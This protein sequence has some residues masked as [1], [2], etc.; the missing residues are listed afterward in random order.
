MA[1]DPSAV[2]RLARL[3][4]RTQL[5]VEGVLSG[6]HRSP[7]HGQSVEFSEHKEYSPGDEVRH[8]DWK[9]YG[10]FDRYYIKRFE[11]ETNLRAYLVL[12]ASAS[13]GYGEPESK[14]ATATAMAGALASLLAGQQDAVGLAIAHGGDVSVVPA[15]SSPGHLNAIMERL[16]TIQPSGPTDLARLADALAEKTRRRALLLVFSDLFD[17]NPDGLRRLLVLRAQQ[18]DLCLFHLLDRTELAFPFDDP[19]LFLSMED[20]R[21]LEA[22]PRELRKGY[23]EELG[24]FLSTARRLSRERDCDYQL[25]ATDEPLESALIAFLSRRDRRGGGDSVTAEKADFSEV[26]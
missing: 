8:I 16:A 15:R 24:R 9:A 10:K 25:V 11:Q 20:S 14:W 17:E 12:D 5:L 3:R 2:A 18:H 13:M 6:L 7:H 1:L 21:R 4:L 22:N 23:L 26:S 19:T